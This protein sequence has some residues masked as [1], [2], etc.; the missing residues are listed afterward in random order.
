M[1]RG[2]HW[3]GVAFGHL[4]RPVPPILAKPFGNGWRITGIAPWMT[5][6]PLLSD[7]IVGAQ[8]PD[9]T[10]LYALVS[11]AQAA[12]VA[13]S[14]PMPLSAMGAT[15]TV[16]VEFQDCPIAETDLIRI[17]DPGEM[18]GGDRANLLKTTAPLLGL[19]GAALRTARSGLANRP[20]SGAD[21]SLTGLDSE[22][23]FLRDRILSELARPIA[24]T[25][26]RTHRRMRSESID[27]AQ[28]CAMASVVV[29]AG[30]ANTVGHPAQRH[31]REAA[32]YAVFQQTSAIASSALECFADRRPR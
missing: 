13:V 14:A 32:F 10:H 29:S 3:V 27:L 22:R 12:G 5:G 21:V 11:L 4:R 8:L 31:L 18:A 20:I 30:A 16:Q 15:G 23:L 19:S 17:A 9:G 2:E 26:E 6:W 24:S 25:D 1:S 28:R 7:C